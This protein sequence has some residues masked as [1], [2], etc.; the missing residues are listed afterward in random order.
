MPSLLAAFFSSFIATL[1]IIRYKHL[2]ARFSADSDLLGP[3]KFHTTAVPRIGGIS[4]AVGLFIGI[5]LKL[6]NSPDS[7]IAIVLFLSAIPTFA[8]G[9]TEDLTKKISV[10]HRL[11]FTAMASGLFVYLLQSPISRLDIPYLDMIFIIPGV[12]ALLTIFAI[13]G[14][15]NAY[16]II[17]GFNGLASMVGTITLLAIA[18][19]GLL[20]ADPLII[21]LSLI[22]ASAILGFFIWNYPRG[23]IFLGDGGAYLIGFWIACLSVLLTCRH[24]EVS[25]WF[26]LLINGYPIVETLFTIYRRKMHQNKSPGLPDGIH[27]HTLIYRRILAPHHQSQNLFSANA[28][29]APYLWMLAAI[30]ITPAV[31]W[32]QSTPILMVASLIFLIF[33]VWLYKRIVQFKTPKCIFPE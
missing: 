27:F 11:L 7:S 30:S 9:L 25:A 2:H 17:D 29:T 6:K 28:K 19:V 12:G 13:T 1:L 32:W 15:A 3:Q 22:M 5:L 26:A 23:L 10:R 18:Y 21:Y 24:Q 31:L 14:L 20:L 4:I 16:N 33:Y 8:I